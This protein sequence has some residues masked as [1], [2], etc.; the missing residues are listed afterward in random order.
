MSQGPTEP[1][2]LQFQ[3]QV[4]SFYP[5]SAVSASALQ[6]RNWYNDL[7]RNFDP[8]L[9]ADI[10]V[11]DAALAAQSR[12][13]AIRFYRPSSAAEG[14]GIIYL[15]G[16]GFV[17]GGLDS[18]HSICADLAH[19]ARAT[20]VAVD[21]RLAPEHPWPA[22]FEDCRAVL[23][24]AATRF[25]RIILAGDSAGGNLAAG[26]ALWARDSNVREVVGQALVYPGLGGDL[27]QGSYTEMA[28]A[29]GL[30]TADVRYYRQLLSAPDGDPY[31]YPLRAEDLDGV[32]SAFV[33]VARYD[34]LRDDGR[35]YSARLALAGVDVHFRE[36]PQMVHAWLRARNSSPGA[37]AGFAALCGW[38][39]RTV[40]AHM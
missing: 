31:A 6:Q 38:L 22:A 9:P 17:V 36:E 37:R 3:R 19:A 2:I 23:I 4:N 20:L 1:E 28:N 16:G 39:R 30:T 11:A 13:I 35:A 40:A 5:P 7:C 21:Y 26:L 25:R 12:S 29:P 8:P 32:A 18:H 15:H 24:D 34:P 33:T 27:D 10:E 14:I